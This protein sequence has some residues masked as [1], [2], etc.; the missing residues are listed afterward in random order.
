[1]VKFENHGFRNGSEVCL[2]KKE[3]A[4]WLINVFSTDQQNLQRF[5]RQHRIHGQIC[6]VALRCSEAVAILPRNSGQHGQS[7]L[8]GPAKT[9][10]CYSLTFRDH[11]HDMISNSMP[12]LKKKYLFCLA[13]SM[14]SSH[15]S[16]FTYLFYHFIYPLVNSHITMGK[17]NV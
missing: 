5:F 1:M 16:H 3:L 6:V 11:S 7:I 17:D 13:T 14:I 8:D 9:V 10:P 4:T 2:A 15:T 12:R